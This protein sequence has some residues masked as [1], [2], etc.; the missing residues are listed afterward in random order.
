MCSRLW[1]GAPRTGH[2]QTCGCCC[3]SC[4][5]P[6]LGCSL[7]GAC[8]WCWSGAVSGSGGT[9]QVKGRPSTNAECM[10]TTHL[11][12][13]TASSGSSWTSG[14]TSSRLQGTKRIVLRTKHHKSF[15]NWP[16]LSPKPW[17]WNSKDL[18]PCHLLV[19]QLGTAVW[20]RKYTWI[21]LCPLRIVPCPLPA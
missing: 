20:K 11:A 19:C 9:R 7:Q 6:C 3:I 18:G 13:V 8:S 4:M 2:A 5:R 12:S 15:T 10:T 21:L 17:N 16:V 14:S 1:A